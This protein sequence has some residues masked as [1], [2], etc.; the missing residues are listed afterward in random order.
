MHH[1]ILHLGGED[2]FDLFGGTLKKNRDGKLAA[3]EKSQAIIEFKLDGTILYANKNFLDALGYMLEEIKG[4]HHSM[5]VDPV[6][7]NSPEYREFWAKL[8]RGEFQ[9]A[10]YK[11]IGKNGKEIWIRATYNPILDRNGRPYMV[12]K[13]AI[14]V[15]ADKLK[16]ADYEGQLKAI[17]KS[18]AVIEFDLDGKIITANQN[19]L[20]AL[21]YTL[22]EVRGQHHSMFVDH[23]T[24]ASDGYR[25]FWEALK[26]GEYQAN[27]FKRI[28]KDGKEVWIQA[29]YNP[30]LDLSGRPFKV[31]KFATDITNMVVTRIKQAEALK[32]INAG[33]T[34][35]GGAVASASTQATS[36]SAA[37][38]QTTANVQAVA[39]GAE[40]LSASVMEISQSMTKSRDE[41]DKA[42]ARAADADKSTQR[43][44]EAAQAMS[45][46]VALIQN[47]AGQINLLALNAT[48]ESARA[49]DA[50]KGFAVVASE[51]KNLARQAADATEKISGE[52]DGIQNITK[53][54]VSG[55]ANIRSSIETVRE[56]VAATASA[57]EEQSAVTK[58][59]S[60]NM[61]TAAAA[62]ENITTSVKAIADAASEADKSTS[63]VRQASSALAA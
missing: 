60:Q 5:F 46:I 15:T 19:F 17:G 58:D 28:G 36:A 56:Y 42:F 51:V 34:S 8:N 52:I 21:G 1:N 9:A 11:R 48:I 23:I 16:A 2:M 22:D 61:Q 55:L 14:D 54:V 30:I 40:E 47:I 26:H 20:N 18:S 10:E 33:L 12:V 24:R 62:V 32:I 63:E 41:A 29:S 49:G 39:A 27:E 45:N 43:L 7:R 59:M 25:Q 31:V 50:G 35:I 57:V 38:T 4:K 37:S 6:E 13:F 44:T 3:L 53:D